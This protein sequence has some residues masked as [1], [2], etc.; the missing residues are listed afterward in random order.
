MA[1]GHH[2]QGRLP[3]AAPATWD[4]VLAAAKTDRRQKAAPWGATFDA[5]GWRSLAPITHSMS[6]KVYTPEGLF[7]FTSEPAIEALKLMKQIMAL[8]ESRH[9]AGRRLRRRRQRHA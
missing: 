8:L 5:H 6:T 3:D 9:P 4:D 7:D 1:L 2:G